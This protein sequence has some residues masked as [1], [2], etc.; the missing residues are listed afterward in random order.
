MYP[1]ADPLALQLL[2]QLLRSNPLERITAEQALAHPWFADLHDVEL[3]PA[4]PGMP[5]DEPSMHLS[6]YTLPIS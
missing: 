6:A 2:N 3:E 5:W 4:A 1:D